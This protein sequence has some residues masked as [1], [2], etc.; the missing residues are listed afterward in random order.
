MYCDYV[1]DKRYQLADWRIR[2]LPQEMLDYARS[3]THFLLFIYDN[4]RNALLDRSRSRSSSPSS[5]SHKPQHALLT[6]VLTRSAETSLRVY[7]KE[8]YD[9]ADGSGPGGWDTLA[10]KWNKGALMAG[11][12]GVGIGAMQREV[13][14][15]VHSWRERVAREED[16]STRYVV[17]RHVSFYSNINLVW[18]RYTMPNQYLFQLAEQPPADMA[19]LLG[20]FKSSVPALVRRRAKELLEVIREGVRQ[21]LEGKQVA[22]VEEEANETGSEV[23]AQDAASKENMDVDSMPPQSSSS[24]SFWG[25]GT[26]FDIMRY[27]TPFNLLSLW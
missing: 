18:S 3:D 19:A 20:V 21:G 6:Q 17:L 22:K 5:S 14:V 9:A 2:P 23:V 12:P 13:Y 1:P 8:P 10:K 25:K 11:G 27:G 15:R 16:E 4:L 24:Q 26:S 7:V